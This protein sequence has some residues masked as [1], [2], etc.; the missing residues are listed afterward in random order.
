VTPEEQS[1]ESVFAELYLNNKYIEVIEIPLT[2]S[3]SR[4]ELAWRFQLPHDQYKLSLRPLKTKGKHTVTLTDLVV[5]D[6]PTN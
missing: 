1:D 4:P 2:R 6:V 3:K 5:Y